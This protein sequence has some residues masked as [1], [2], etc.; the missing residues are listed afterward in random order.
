[1]SKMLFKCIVISI[2]LLIQL[3]FMS[4][5]SMAYFDLQ[6]MYKA[7]EQYKRIAVY[8]GWPTIPEGPSLKLND[9]DDRV[10]IIR[11]RLQLTGEL[12]NSIEVED[13]KLFDKSLENAVKNFQKN[14]GLE[15]EGIVDENTLRELNIKCENRI[16]QISQN[17]IEMERY[18]EELGQEYII[19]NIPDF[20]MKYINNNETI[21]EKKV[22]VGKLWSRTP[23]FNDKITYLVLNPSWII[24][25]NT[26][27]STY[28]PLIQSNPDSFSNRDIRVFNVSG[29]NKREVSTVA[30]DWSKINSKNF[31]YRLEQDPGSQN[32]MG[33]VKFKFPNK[34]NVYLHG[35]PDKELFN[36]RIRM[37]SSGCIRLENPIE[38]AKAILENYPIFPRI[39]EIIEKKITKTVILEEA[40][41]IYIVY[42]TV[43]VDE[44]GELNFRKDI[45]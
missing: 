21:L 19:V 42:W 24:P 18:S 9:Y 16:K 15:D 20:H 2:F 34:Y 36:E 35:T 7:I 25:F 28:I 10:V 37:Y 41:A 30:I 6:A 23:V 31:V 29:R 26:A 3:L 43:W 5:N 17:I 44:N 12:K 13:L 32:P 27:I 4:V 1:M 14:H 39:D 45:Y 11:E 40:L 38:L 33:V 22:I 8:G